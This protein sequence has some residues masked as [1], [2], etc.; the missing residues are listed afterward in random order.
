M[1]FYALKRFPHSKEIRFGFLCVAANHKAAEKIGEQYKTTE[2][3][4]VGEIREFQQ[5]LE[6]IQKNVHPPKA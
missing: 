6:D 5:L 1:T 4:A 3:L 2:V